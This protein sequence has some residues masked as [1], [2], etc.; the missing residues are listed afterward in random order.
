M[1]KSIFASICILFSVSVF[2]Q[3][4][5]DF[6]MQK[7]PQENWQIQ[8]SKW[9]TAGNVVLN[10]LN[11]KKSVITPGNGILV[12]KASSGVLSSGLATQDI[13]L[14]FRFVL[15]AGADTRFN[16]G[17]G[18][19]VLLEN[20]GKTSGVTGSIS[21]DNGKIITPLADAGKSVGL[22]QTLE[23]VYSPAKTASESTVIEKL[24]LNGLTIHE[25]VFISNQ[26]ASSVNDKF[27]FDNQ[28]GFFAVKDFEY[29]QFGN[30]KPVSLS[31]LSYTL[32]E[33]NGFDRSFEAKATPPVS[34]KTPVLSYDVP[35]D[36]NR[37]IINFKGKLKV[38][39][40]GKYAFT[41]D[42]QGAGHLKID[43][44]QVTG[45]KEWTYR[46]PM[47]GMIDLTAGEHD[48]EYQYQT[49]FWRPAMGLFVS[50][51]K[52][53]PYALHVSS[54]LP[55]PEMKGGVFAEPSG[56]KAQ[57]I[58]SFVFFKDK[59]RTK[60]ISVGTPQQVHY[61]F[62]LDNAALL[63]A[64]RGDFANVTDMWLERGEPQVIKPIGLKTELSGRVPF[65]ANGGSPLDSV[66]VYREFINTSYSLNDQGLPKF[67]YKWKNSTFSLE[68]TPSGSDLNVSVNASDYHGFSIL[69]DQGQEIVKIE[70]GLYQVDDHYIKTD[71]K[72]KPEIISAGKSK[73]LV[74]GLNK[75]LNYSIIW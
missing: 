45:S 17:N 72:L 35:N 69:L 29:L 60:V 16:L 38:D 43:G 22:W 8:G 37:Y 58:R 20:T 41:M 32:Q 62:D 15:G 2:A 31:E 59:K 11:T 67:N 30:N 66:D 52:I 7:L 74:T 24:V 49:I 3:E 65:Y 9:E 44:K 42:Y 51:G 70:N 4:G 71:P 19:A 56:D 27:T 5:S 14:K 26:K 75:Q 28:Q 36:Y 25:N 68:Y 46:E 63:Y 21:I 54:S 1:I 61:T 39:E 64:W 6:P 34:G 12:A 23:L 50:S 18:I 55:L 33:T 73:Q 47:T 13:K 48:F 40:A 10:P 57:L 53:R